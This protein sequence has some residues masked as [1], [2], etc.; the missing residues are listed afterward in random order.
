MKLE[1]RTMFVAARMI[2]AGMSTRAPKAHRQCALGEPGAAERDAHQHRFDN[3]RRRQCQQRA[4][5]H[6]GKSQSRGLAEAAEFEPRAA[7]RFASRPARVDVI[8]DPAVEVV[9][10]FSI[11]L[12]FELGWG[13]PARCAAAG[14]SR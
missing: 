12:A 14:T 10:D 8:V 2:V 6:A 11:Q 13:C 5:D 3:A 4:D 9:P 7:E 1:S